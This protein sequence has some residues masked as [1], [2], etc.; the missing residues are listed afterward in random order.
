MCSVAPTPYGSP[1]K[2]P[3]RMIQAECALKQHF[4]QKLFSS[5]TSSESRKKESGG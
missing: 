5:N 3:N 1:M 2:L 4:K